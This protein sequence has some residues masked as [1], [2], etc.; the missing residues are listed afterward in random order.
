MNWPSDANGLRQVLERLRVDHA[1]AVWNRDDD[2]VEV[3]EALIAECGRRLQSGGSARPLQETGE[4]ARTETTTE[5]SSSGPP[6]CTD[7]GAAVP[8]PFSHVRFVGSAAPPTAALPPA[9]QPAPAPTMPAPA[10]PEVSPAPAPPPP[11]VP[12]AV[13]PAP[14]PSARVKPLAAGWSAGPRVCARCGHPARRGSCACSAGPTSKRQ[15]ASPRP[16]S[17]AP[18]RLWT[19]LPASGDSDTESEGRL[20]QPHRAQ[21][22]SPLPYARSQHARW[23]TASPRLESHSSPRSPGSPSQS[24]G[25][26]GEGQGGSRLRGFAARSGDEVVYCCWGSCS[27]AE[28][29]DVPARASS[30]SLPSRSVLTP[31]NRY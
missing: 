10:P 7:D 27:A 4:A 5:S 22:L 8:L 18:T 28:V 16:K 1:S 17:A 25:W 6:V 23:V 12:P 13:P 31:G 19:S 26:S 11:A 3:V 20:S 14:A 2:A 29:A 15:L 30:P 21:L 9:A 24:V